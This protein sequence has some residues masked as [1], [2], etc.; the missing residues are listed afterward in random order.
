MLCPECERDLVG[1]SCSC[2]WSQPKLNVAQ[3]YVIQHCEVC[4]NVAIQ[5]PIGATL[6]HPTCKWCLAKEHAKGAA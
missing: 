1:S 3:K 4:K 5:V 6:A 2:G